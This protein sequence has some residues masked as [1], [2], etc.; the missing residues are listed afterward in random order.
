MRQKIVYRVR[1]VYRRTCLNFFYGS[2]PN[3]GGPY[4]PFGDA[5]DFRRMPST[6][7][8]VLPISKIANDLGMDTSRA[9]QA[10]LAVD[11]PRSFVVVHGV[12]ATT[13]SEAMRATRLG[14]FLYSSRLGSADRVA[15]ISYDVDRS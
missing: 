11:L 4:R 14:R 3:H 15:A 5:Q 7:E 13:P 2:R 1:A 10:Q 8:L 6:W 9:L 12:R